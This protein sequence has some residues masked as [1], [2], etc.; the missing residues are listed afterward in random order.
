MQFYRAQAK[1]SVR[2]ALTGKFYQQAT[3]V[4]SAAARDRILIEP[5]NHGSTTARFEIPKRSLVEGREGGPGMG[6]QIGAKPDSGFDDPIGMLKD[7]HRRIEHFLQSCA[8]LWNE[9]RDGP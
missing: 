9:Q 3:L 7:C 1:R 6:I 2:G 8:W 5:E 4:S